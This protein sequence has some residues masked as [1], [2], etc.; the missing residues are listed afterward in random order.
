MPI[1]NVSVCV[2][3]DVQL[4]QLLALGSGHWYAN[5]TIQSGQSQ[6]HKSG[7]LPQYSHPVSSCYVSLST[8]RPL[9]E[10]KSPEAKHSPG[11]L[12]GTPE[13]QHVLR[14]I[15]YTDSGLHVRQLGPL[16]HTGMS[17]IRSSFKICYI[18]KSI[19]FP[20]QCISCG[21]LQDYFFEHQLQFEELWDKVLVIPFHL[22]QSN[23]RYN[24][25]CCGA[26]EMG[27]PT[28]V[29]LPL[30]SNYKC[31]PSAWDT[32]WNNSTLNEVYELIQADENEVRSFNNVTCSC[33]NQLT[34][35][36]VTGTG[37]VPPVTQT[38]R[39]GPSGVWSAK[40]FVYC[41][42][43]FQIYITLHFIY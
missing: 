10:F 28:S 16:L 40:Q 35:Y 37:Y 23:E 18:M 20:S 26:P 4:N 2:S 32:L 7:Q 19:C 6:S 38:L 33:T 36:C 25:T 31:T 15:H 12:F 11:Q 1:E 14:P 21:N 29:V 3:Q 13:Y 43:N 24:C 42:Q 39:D 27:H 41:T 17:V 5:L 8:C 9:A 30:K 34:R 22:I